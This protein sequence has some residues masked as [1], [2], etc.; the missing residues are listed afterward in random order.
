MHE[1]EL[2]QKCSNSQSFEPIM[3][4]LEH[5]SFLLSTWRNLLSSFFHLLSTKFVLHSLDIT[6]HNVTWISTNR[7]N[8]AIF[9]NYYFTFIS[10]AMIFLECRLS[11]CMVRISFNRNGLIYANYLQITN[12]FLRYRLTD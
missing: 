4:Y 5:L 6:R 7:Y 2:L 8:F 9:L 1:H 12:S 3:G 10:I 11:N